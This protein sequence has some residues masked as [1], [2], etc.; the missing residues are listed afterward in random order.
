[1]IVVNTLNA[2]AVSGEGEATAD[3]TPSLRV[4][5]VPAELGVLSFNTLSDA[6]PPTAIEPAAPAGS[7]SPIKP[8]STGTGVCTPVF[9]AV[10]A[11][12][13]GSVF[14]AWDGGESEWEQTLA[15]IA[16][17]D[18]VTDREAATDALL[19]SLFG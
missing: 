14:D 2:A 18:G 6:A 19:G 3:A 11:D 15:S 9:Q 17:G 12:P 4:M 16:E 10:S 8:R 7:R 1:L 5:S 13:Q